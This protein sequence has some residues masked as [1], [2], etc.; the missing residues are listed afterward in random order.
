M[1][2]ARLTGAA[3]AT[4][5]CLALALP[6]A[7][8]WPLAFVAYF[9][10]LLVLPEL[11]SKK[12]FLVGWLAGVAANAAIFHWICHTAMTMSDFP[13]LPAVLVT[14]AYALFSGMSVG[15]SA[16]LASHLL[17]SRASALLVPAAVVSAEWCWPHLFPWQV[18]NAFFRTPIL[19]Q[20][21]DL[22]G[23]NGATFV[24][25]SFS[26]A[27]AA[28]AR[29]RRWAVLP[30]VLVLVSWLGYGAMRLHEVRNATPA[31]VVRLALVQPD[32]TAEDKKRKD[33]ANRKALFARLKDLTLS[34][35]LSKVDA[36]VWPE[37]AF[38]YYFALDAQG[39][40]G[41]EHILETSNRLVA[42]VREA[43]RSLIFGTLTK[44]FE[45]ARNSVVMLAPDGSEVARYDKQRLLAFGEYMPLSD[46]IPGLKHAVKEVGD[47]EA[48]KRAVA[49]Q[50]GQ[51]KALI[52]IC[53]EAILAAF[54]REALNKT[55][56][57]L[58]LNVTNDAWFGE[59]GA[60]AQHLMVQV[61]R[62]VELRV[63]L[64]RV[65]QTGISAVVS[66]GGDFLYETA[67]HERRVD[68]VEV[69]FGLDI[70]SPYRFSG[71]AFGWLC[72]AATILGLRVPLRHYLRG[73]KSRST[74]TG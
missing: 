65:T 30:G 45:R 2:Y 12:A 71:D 37:G 41:Y 17:A 70:Q 55:A 73:K 68:V 47:M 8:L 40:Q 9:P 10:L 72:I 33:H 23:V 32:I 3:L 26:T 64:V 27:L 15:V 34:A 50:I 14:L 29:G 7:S 63:P 20:G 18:G 35:D 60:Q 66:P 5:L 58:I 4:A 28:L 22:T 48:G 19:L 25:V 67:P 52:S 56:A 44:P 43:N 13:L 74:S 57:D 54:T 49:F 69:P 46:L 39:R 62:A 1:R 59:S 21:M 36:V 51:A 61:P 53:Y 11:G 16:T 31:G 42:M 6:D 38:S 24:A